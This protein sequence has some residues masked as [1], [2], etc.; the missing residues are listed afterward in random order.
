MAPTCPKSRPG[1][2]KRDDEV[3]PPDDSATASA[4]WSIK[5]CAGHRVHDVHLGLCR[6]ECG[7]ESQATGRTLRE[8]PEALQVSTDHAEDRDRSMSQD[9]RL[10]LIEQ[11]A[12]HQIEE[13]SDRRFAG[14]AINQDTD[15]TATE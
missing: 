4:V 3:A 1:R 5:N 2:Q 10:G 14:H 13:H 11:T 12:H 15:R 9:N 6:F 8:L 7:T